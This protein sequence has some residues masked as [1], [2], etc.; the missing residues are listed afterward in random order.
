MITFNVV[1]R[2]ELERLIAEQQRATELAVEKEEELYQLHESHLT[3]IAAQ[4]EYLDLLKAQ[5][6]AERNA[7]WR[8]IDQQRQMLIKEQQARG[9]F[10][11]CGQPAMASSHQSSPELSF[12]TSYFG[13]L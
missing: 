3:E 7:A 12:T 9:E 10:E 1:R 8:E 4:R 2:K 11:V 6:E 5:Y 13:M